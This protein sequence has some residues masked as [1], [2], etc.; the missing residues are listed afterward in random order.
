MF[1]NVNNN[2]NNFPKIFYFLFLGSNRSTSTNKLLEYRHNKQKFN[3]KSRKCKKCN[4]Q[5]HQDGKYCSVCSYK[6]GKC[7]MCGKT[8]T[9][10]S[11]SNM[12]IV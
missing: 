12:S 9:D 1:Q 10:V 3:P 7:Q 2:N 5:L 4:S 11:S 8:I 6:L